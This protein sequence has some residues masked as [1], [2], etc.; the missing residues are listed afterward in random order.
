MKISRREFVHTSVASGAAVCSGLIVAGCGNDVA[1]APVLPQPLKL[2]PDG[3]LLVN[4]KVMGPSGP[5]DRYPDLA[6][7]GG[8]I[9]ILVDAG[10]M[11][12]VTSS[13]L[14]IHRADENSVPPGELA[15]VAVNSL[16]PH[17]GCPLGYSQQDQL[18]ECPCHASR[19]LA[20]PQ[21]QS[22]GQVVHLPALQGTPAYPVTLSPDFTTLT[23]QLQCAASISFAD[24]PELREPGGAAVIQP[25]EI[26]CPVVII[27][28]GEEQVLVLDA[29]CTHQQCT[30]AVNADARELDCPCHGSRFDYDG[31]VLN[32]PA[33]L[34]LP[35]LHAKLT[36]NGV[37]VNK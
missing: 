30:V 28:K 3:T 9:T 33:T 32:G 24:H 12:G 27:R 34:P 21:L 36:R 18:I 1:P 37:D 5:I 6:P 2:N 35:Q 10:G 11:A 22:V 31:K 25:P 17:A 29:R 19:F 15:Y 20:G 23:I 8:A 7:I 13:V 26:A 4:L 16:C 14:L